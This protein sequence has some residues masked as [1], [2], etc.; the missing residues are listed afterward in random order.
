MV[1]AFDATI[2]GWARAL[3]FLEWELTGYL[4][5]L[6]VEANPIEARIFAVAIVWAALRSAYPYH[7]AWPAPKIFRRI[8]PP[9]GAHFDP[10]AVESFDQVFA[11]R[12]SLNPIV[13]VWSP[14]HRDSSLDGSRILLS[15]EAP[16]DARIL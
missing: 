5:G 9:A 7:A 14:A 11:R 2:K 4:N 12:A 15:K 6:T 10:S 8:Q 1:V 13:M 16:S 3:K